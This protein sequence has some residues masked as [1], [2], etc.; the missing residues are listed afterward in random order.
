MGNDTRAQLLVDLVFHINYVCVC[1]GVCPA[2]QAV[3]A[4]GCNAT[5]T[6]SPDLLNWSHAY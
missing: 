4:H 3:T 6:R 5:K 1:M 2:V